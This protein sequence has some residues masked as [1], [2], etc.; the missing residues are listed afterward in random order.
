MLLADLG[1][2]VVK[3]ETVK[4]GDDTRSW[5]PPAWEGHSTVFLSANR[6]KRSLAVDLN[7]VEGQHVVRRL[8]GTADIVVESF[9]PGS[10]EK[11]GL[12]YSTLQAL[13]P[14]LIYCSITAYGGHGPKA[15]LAGYDPVLQA[16]TG[17]LDVTGDP[18]GKAARLGIGAIDLGTALWAVV[19]IQAA[20]THRLAT[21]RGCHVEAS[22]FETSA[23]W[24]SYHL[25]GYLATGA[26]PTRQGTAATF[27]APY[28]VFPTADGEI[29][30][31]TPNDR[32]FGV[33][34]HELGMPQLTDD[35]RFQANDSRVRNRGLLRELIGDALRTRPALEWEEAL[36]RRSIPCS[37]V[38]TVADMAG[39]EQLE[40]LGVWA[41]VPHPE[42]GDLR[43]IGTPVSIDRSRGAARR[44]PPRLGEHTD[45][46]LGEL[47]L[48]AD[49]IAA[50]RAAGTA[51]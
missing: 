21:G 30:I 19:G 27:I 23:W 8:A 31:A 45:E 18:E 43:L 44:H 49:E 33:L 22:L 11:R 5:R 6:N 37:V 13:N 28:E 15:G 39:D 35:T 14:A 36:R 12:D 16:D 1:A 25:L 46:V 20:L 47:G 50:M 2:D 48:T 51:Q 24:L 4:D 10:L 3:V 32:L 40:A 34:A 26:T 9:R 41:E 7:S 42:L 17:I 29:M 38:R